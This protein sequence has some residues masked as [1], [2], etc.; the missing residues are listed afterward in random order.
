MSIVNTYISNAHTPILTVP[1][2]KKYA[3]TFVNICNY[4]A[5]DTTCDLH[6]VANGNSVDAKTTLKVGIPLV[7]GDAFQF[8]IEKI[9]LDAGDVLYATAGANSL[10]SACVSYIDIT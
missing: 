10:L 4:G 1:S 6:L 2:A 7:V 9:I 8:D 3:I 5:Q